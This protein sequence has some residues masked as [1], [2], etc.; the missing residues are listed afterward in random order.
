MKRLRELSPGPDSVTLRLTKQIDPLGR[1][2]SPPKLF[3]YLYSK[4][5]TVTV[6]GRGGR[7]TTL[8]RAGPPVTHYRLCPGPSTVSL[9]V[10]RRPSRVLEESRNPL[11]IV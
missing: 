3:D 10:P 2:L 7:C 8:R 1:Y 6:V 11:F 4:Q 9:H 5:E